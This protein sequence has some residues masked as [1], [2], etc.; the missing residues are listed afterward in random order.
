MR[1][2][3]VESLEDIQADYANKQAQLEEIKKIFY[4]ADFLEYNKP[5]GIAFEKDLDDEENNYK[6]QFYIDTTAY[7]Y[8]CYITVTTGA[9]Q[10]N[11]ASK[12]DFSNLIPAVNRFLDE[13]N[14]I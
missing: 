3:L 1:F 14:K 11:Y 4:E 2:K 9:S 6:A 5:N 13:L 7:V 10:V 12:G 8:S